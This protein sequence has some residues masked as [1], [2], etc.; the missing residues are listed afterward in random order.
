MLPRVA[1]SLQV[2]Q[3]FLLSSGDLAISGPGYFVVRDPDTSQCYATR[4]GD[5]QL[6]S[7]SRLI[8]GE[9][10]RVQGFCDGTLTNVGDITINNSVSQN[11]SFELVAAYTINPNGEILAWLVD[12]T[13]FVIG[14]IL[15]Q[16]F[17]HPETLRKAGKYI[18]AWDATAGPLPESQPP[19]TNRLGLLQID[20]LELPVTTLKL[21][22][23]QGSPPLLAHG[24]L[25]QTGVPTDLGIEGNGFFILRDTNNQALFATRAGTFLVDPEGYLVNYSGLR[26]QGFKDVNQSVIGDLQ[27]NGWGVILE[28]SITRSGDVLFI[29][30]DGASGYAGRILLRDC[31]Q[32]AQLIQT[33]Y[34]L[35]PVNSNGADWTPM[36]VPG[37]NGFGWI[38]YGTVETKQFDDDILAVRR[39]LNNFPQ[40]Y[41]QYTGNATDLAING[42]GFFIVRNPA[43][44][45][46]YATRDGSFQL[47]AGGY[48][49]ATNGWRV[50]DL[51]SPGFVTPGDVMV[52]TAQKPAGHDGTT[53]AAFYFANDGKIIVLLSDG[54]SYARGQIGLQYFWN[55]QALQTSDGIYFTN[56]AAALP[57]F[58]NGSPGY[59]GLGNIVSG[60]LEGIPYY[61]LP[62]LAPQPQSGFCVQ[63]SNLLD[64]ATTLEA[65]A[66]LVHWTPL[67]Q[68]Q[69][70]DIGA[71]EF[72]DTNLPAALGRFYRTKISSGATV[73]GVAQTPLP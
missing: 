64:G 61:R 3:T 22:R 12:G 25:H 20:S 52:D 66:D 68:I 21:S 43:D 47:D 45:S 2:T 65:S 71:A 59:S 30:P 16:N 49:V 11:G 51:T 38:A 17:S 1:L 28:F 62:E 39:K 46:F 15:L 32:P 4:F 7:D 6:D 70:N 42:F 60:T 24:L 34:S 19:G 73:L 55:L 5:F 13:S 14:Q 8:S 23:I 56:L 26:V 50:E 36:T 48:L 63:A 72:F 18:Y 33:N 67:V 10:L 58:D 9:G 27:V 57:M 54:T 40:G 29:E 69:A 53:M 41:I 31:R 44:N 35:F 37:Q